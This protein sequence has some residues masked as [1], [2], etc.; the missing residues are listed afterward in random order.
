MGLIGTLMFERPYRVHS[1]FPG[2]RPGGNGSGWGFGSSDSDTWGWDA[3]YSAHVDD[4][5]LSIVKFGGLALLSN[6][7]IV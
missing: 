2:Q 6:R 5:D 3:F 7:S 4:H 1:G